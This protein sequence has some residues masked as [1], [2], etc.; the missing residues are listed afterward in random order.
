MYNEPHYQLPAAPFFSDHAI[1]DYTDNYLGFAELPYSQM[2]E[3]SEVPF[4]PGQDS[5]STR[6]PHSVSAIETSRNSDP[7]SVE[8]A[9][10]PS[11]EGLMFESAEFTNT[12]FAI[13]NQANYPSIADHT[14]S[15]YGQSSRP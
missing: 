14:C 9:N 5:S 3:P 13:H 11:D 2:P 6:L 15:Q 10:W 8:A 7:N 1:N 12:P 4:R